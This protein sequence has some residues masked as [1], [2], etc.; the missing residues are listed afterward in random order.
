MLSAAQIPGYYLKL[1]Y[2]RRHRA[3]GLTGIQSMPLLK[4]KRKFRVKTLADAEVVKEWQP[5][6]RICSV[7]TEQP[8]VQQ[9]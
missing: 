6:L 5:F 9:N 2:P 7:A 4:S 1:P 8:V 3:T